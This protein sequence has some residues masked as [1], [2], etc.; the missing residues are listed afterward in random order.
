MVGSGIRI[1][2]P[3]ITTRGMDEAEMDRIGDLL[4][5]AL[6][7]PND[8]AI[9][10]AVKADVEALCREFPLYPE[11]LGLAALGPLD[12]VGPRAGEQV[13]KISRK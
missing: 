8:E 13:G 12:V 2:T 3:A 1:G 5:R 10:A 4:A 11:S 6:A 7:A 9:L